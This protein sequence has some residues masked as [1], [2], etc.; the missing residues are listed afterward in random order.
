MALQ[1]VQVLGLE[2][3]LRRVNRSSQIVSFLLDL[4]EFL[5]GQSLVLPPEE[6]PFSQ[7]IEH[8]ANPARNSRPQLMKSGDYTSLRRLFAFFEVNECNRDLSPIAGPLPLDS[9]QI[10][11]H[12]NVLPDGQGTTD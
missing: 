5:F 9:G 10:A 7:R 4:S 1:A 11:L 6:Q 2:L 12:A 3:P 8:G